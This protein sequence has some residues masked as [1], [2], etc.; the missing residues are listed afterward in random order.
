MSVLVEIYTYGS[1]YDQV[2]FYASDIKS[3]IKQINEYIEENNLNGTSYT[4]E[5]VE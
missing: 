1:F 4:L 2:K 3:L 5:I